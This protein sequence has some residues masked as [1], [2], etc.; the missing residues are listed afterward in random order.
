MSIPRIL[1]EHQ[2]GKKILSTIEEATTVLTASL[3]WYQ[4]KS[5]CTLPISS[6]KTLKS[7]IIQ[8]IQ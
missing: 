2:K 1:F 6:D 7:D 8:V 3:K 4:T 5:M